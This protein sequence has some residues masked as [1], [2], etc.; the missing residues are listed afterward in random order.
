MWPFLWSGYTSSLHGGLSTIGLLIWWL[1]VPESA[2]A[3]AA[4][5]SWPSLAQHHVL[6]IL[7]VKVFHRISA[8]S[9]WEGAA[10]DC[11]PWEMGFIWGPLC[12]PATME[13]VP[14]VR[15]HTP[16]SSVRYVV[17]SSNVREK[18]S[19]ADLQC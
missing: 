4:R 6:C 10:Q 16:R 3:E 1:R 13:D 18:V 7:G 9:E 11:E 14:T 5:S 19:C 2:K 8:D 15:P 12:K 17:R